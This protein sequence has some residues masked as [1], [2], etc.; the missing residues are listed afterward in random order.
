MRLPFL[1]RRPGLLVRGIR[2]NREAP[3]LARLRAI[4]DPD[5]FVWAMLPHAARSFAASILLLPAAQARAAAVGYLY[6]RMLDTYEDLSEPHEAVGSLRAF[7]ARMQTMDPPPAPPTQWRDERDRAH[8]LLIEKYELVDRAFVTLTGEDRSRIVALVQAMADGMVWS[9]GRFAAQG[10]VLV[11]SG[12]LS[13]YC[14]HVIGEPALFTML[15]LGRSNL[16]AQQKHDALASSE[17]IQLANV[18]RDIE[19]DLARGIGYHPALQP[20]LG[21]RDAPAAVHEARSA[22]MAHALPQVSAYTRLAGQMATGRFSLAR[23]AAV[24][25]LLYTDRHY[26]W[27]ADRVGLASWSGPSRSE[28]IL[29]K[30]LPAA[31]SPWWAQRLMQRVERNM[32]TTASVLPERT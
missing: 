18:T 4:E 13:R 16:T 32:L 11:D 15:L 28:V 1:L 30:S 19:K 6:C 2:A 25:M 26:R 7:G 21:Q 22:L 3:D 5:A 12:Q 24:L 20:H 31:L 8:L 29:L 17:L 27:C 14:H 9:T 10:G 23:T